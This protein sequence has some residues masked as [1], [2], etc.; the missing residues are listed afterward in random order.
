MHKDGK[1]AADSLTALEVL[2]LGLRKGDQ[3]GREL[4]YVPLPDNVVTMVEQTWTGNIKSGG[5]AVWTGK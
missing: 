1:D 5:K 4:D 2:R 3:D